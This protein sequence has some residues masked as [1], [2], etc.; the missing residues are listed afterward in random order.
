MNDLLINENIEELKDL[1][2]K[3]NIGELNELIKKMHPHD[4][5]ESLKNLEDNDVEAFYS[6]I[7]EEEVARIVAFLDPVDAA[8]VIDAF[9]LDSQKDIIDNLDLDDAAD[10]FIHLEQQEKLID[11]LENEELISKVLTYEEYQVASHMSDGF[12]YLYLGIDVKEAT[13]KV[14]L[15]AAEVESL[16][17]L[18]VV[19][20]SKR[21]IGTINLRVLIKAKSPLLID[22]LVDSS[23]YVYDTDDIE[24]AIFKIKDYGLYEMAVV[25]SENQLIGVLTV[26]DAIDIYHEEAVE[27]F[28]KLAALPDTTTKGLFTTAIKR[29]PWLLLLLVLSVPIALATSSFEHVIASV[30]VLALFQPLI[31]DAGGD[32]ATQ[33]LAV[34]L[35]VLSKDKK[36]ALKN[37]KN[38][39][40]AGAINGLILGFSGGLISFFIA[41]GLGFLNPLSV[42]LVVAISLTL[43]IIVGA[44]LALIIPIVLDKLN[45]D[46]AVA[47]GPLITTLIDIA[48]VFVYFGLATL[49][50]GVM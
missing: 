39:I 30:A 25:N 9:E 37:G 11:T 44:V 10:I 12:I 48:S 24:E 47:S 27:D 6:L 36:K 28:E 40:L 3:E 35:R 50:L 29:F 2:I 19:D 34:T 4:I 45:A 49:F 42:A 33:T 41:L 46:P 15:E 8:E 20:S 26:D 16:N 23:P 18:F 21:F 32:V 5:I 1:I 17:D 14:I 38:E 13:K 22:E 31:L 43:T 7:G